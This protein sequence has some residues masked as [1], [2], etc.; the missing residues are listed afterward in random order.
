MVAAAPD[1]SHRNLAKVALL[2][3]LGD[4]DTLV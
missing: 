4:F 1:Y 2:T 3:L